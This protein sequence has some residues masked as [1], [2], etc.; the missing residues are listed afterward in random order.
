MQVVQPPVHRAKVFKS[1]NSQAIRIPRGFR[2][3]VDV[4]EIFWRG[5]EL[6][7]RKPRVGLSVAFDILASMPDDFMA[8]GRE[9]NLPQER[10]SWG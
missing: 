9:D 3:D 10:E 8:D 6:V 5:D 1:G 7:L 2:L 4:M